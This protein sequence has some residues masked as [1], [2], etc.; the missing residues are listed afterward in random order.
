MVG[1]DWFVAPHWSFEVDWLF[2]TLF[3]LCLIL[4][5]FSDSSTDQPDREPLTASFS[6]YYH[7]SRSLKMRSDMVRF[8]E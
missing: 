1:G 8:H 7:E 6:N 3:I 5:G 4:L 2:S